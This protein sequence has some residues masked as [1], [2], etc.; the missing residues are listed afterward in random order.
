MKKVFSVL[1]TL[2][3][4]LGLS[5]TMAVPAA[6]SASDYD[7]TLVLENKDADWSVI[8][9]DGIQGTL[10]YVSSANLFWYRFSATGL[11]ASIEYSLIYYADTEDR[12]EDWGGDNPGALIATFETNDSGNIT[13]T[14][15]SVNLNMDLPCS[16]DANAYF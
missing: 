6:V 16:P 1:L 8:A 12:F 7:S 15:D 9:D 11:T 10:E 13:Q 5:L 2:A 14:S 4:V 3:V